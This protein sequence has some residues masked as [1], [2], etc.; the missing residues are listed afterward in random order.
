MNKCFL[1]ILCF[2][3]F[4]FSTI[5][6]TS[7]STRHKDGTNKTV[8]HVKPRIQAIQKEKKANKPLVPGA[9]HLAWN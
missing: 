8:K 3:L 5:K 9:F 4:S 6:A 2:A 7:N 1:A